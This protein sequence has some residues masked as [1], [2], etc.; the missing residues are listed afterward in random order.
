[1]GQPSTAT[2]TN[3]TGNLS[4]VGPHTAY[5]TFSLP[6]SPDPPLTGGIHAGIKIHSATNP[7]DLLFS[8]AALLHFSAGSIRAQPKIPH[9]EDRDPTWAS[10]SDP[11]FV[12]DAG[13]IAVMFEGVAGQTFDVATFAYVERT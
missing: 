4:G 3:E 1:M 11:V 2:Q 7:S 12:V 6:Q 10:V 9:E 5:F 8:F 13:D